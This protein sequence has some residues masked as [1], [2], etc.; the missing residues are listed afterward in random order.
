VIGERA[1][2]ALAAIACACVAIE[3]LAA[4]PPFKLLRFDEDY[5]YLADPSARVDLDDRIKHVRL[6]D[7]AYVSF[8]G[9]WRDVASQSLP[10]DQRRG[11]A[12]GRRAGDPPRRPPRGQ[13][14]DADRPA[15]LLGV[16]AMQR[17]GGAT[18]GTTT[19][20]S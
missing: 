2:H 11:A 20:T 1:R 4:Q 5:A 15:P 10:D 7:S 8:G 6:G 13:L 16:A 12:S 17:S 14:R 19:G 18:A 3:A 9:E